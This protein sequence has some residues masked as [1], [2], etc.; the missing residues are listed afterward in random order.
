MQE[1]KHIQS[2]FLSSKKT[3]SPNDVARS[4]AEL[5]MEGKISAALKLL[6]SENA[7]SGVLNVSDDI[8]KK[9]RVMHLLK[10]FVL[11]IL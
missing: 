1:V 9:L 3:R 8:I 10:T 2:K 5:V 7:S 11:F 6:D 4:F